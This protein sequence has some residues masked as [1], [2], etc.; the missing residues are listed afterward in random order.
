MTGL[1]LPALTDVVRN[2]VLN[3][4]VRSAA[5]SDS[6]VGLY[7]EE[8]LEL[9]LE[10]LEELELFEVLVLLDE[11]QAVSA[12][13]ATI[14]PSANPHVARAA[15]ERGPEDLITAYLSFEVWQNSRSRKALDGTAG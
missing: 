7:W 12:E 9:P 14:A 10:A 11:L 6:G 8:V 15:R 4:A 3:M 2:A 13:V 1:R 5:V